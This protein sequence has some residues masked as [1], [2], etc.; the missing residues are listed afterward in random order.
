MDGWTDGQIHS[1]DKGGKGS[2]RN[3]LIAVFWPVAIFKKPDLLSFLYENEVNIATKLLS[4]QQR[5]DY[6]V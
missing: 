2:S 4:W 6:C 3:E 5:S 1:L